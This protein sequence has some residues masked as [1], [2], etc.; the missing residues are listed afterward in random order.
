MSQLDEI[1]AVVINFLENIS[2]GWYESLFW[3][4][5]SEQKWN[6]EKQIVIDHFEKLLTLT[7]NFC[8]KL[9]FNN[10]AYRPVV[11]SEMLSPAGQEYCQL[12]NTLVKIW[13]RGWVN[14]VSFSALKNA[15]EAVRTCLI[16]YLLKEL[17]NKAHEM[18]STR[19]LERE[20][21]LLKLAFADDRQLRDTYNPYRPL[22]NTKVNER[23]AIQ[24]RQAIENAVTPRPSAIRIIPGSI[25]NIAEAE[26]EVAVAVAAEVEVGQVA[27]LNN[28]AVA[29]S[30]PAVARSITRPG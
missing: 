22:L 1:R 6:D 26:A 16:N 15:M 30:E 21:E 24:L 8:D 2:C 28:S 20:T 9:T 14:A 12:K 10:V 25:F 13:V 11:S 7:P 27:S 29:N 5:T 4:S 3:N 17:I 23:Q 18:W 19:A